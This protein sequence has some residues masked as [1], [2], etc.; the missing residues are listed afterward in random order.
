MITAILNLSQDSYPISVKA[1]L[2]WTDED[3]KQ[4]LSTTVESP[5]RDMSIYKLLVDG[6]DA[7]KKK[8]ET[9][10]KIKTAIAEAKRVD[11]D[12]NPNMVVWDISQLRFNVD[13]LIEHRMGGKRHG[14]A[15]RWKL[16]EGTFEF[17]IYNR[18]LFLVE[19]E[20]DGSANP[21]E[22]A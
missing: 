3:T 11:D 15:I 22:Q 16:P 1:K 6:M 9:I 7:V 21:E 19:D 17:D 10:D 8:A 13:G 5:S 18:R 12:V 20:K 2:A 4:K 14:F